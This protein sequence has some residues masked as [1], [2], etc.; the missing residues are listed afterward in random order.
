MHAR[1]AAEAAATVLAQMMGSADRVRAVMAEA[2]TAGTSTEGPIIAVGVTGMRQAIVKP[3]SI[4]M[5]GCC[6]RVA[7]SMAV[8]VKGLS[9]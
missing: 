7:T 8:K 5:A 6:R 4:M 9:T 2:G 3:H 1:A